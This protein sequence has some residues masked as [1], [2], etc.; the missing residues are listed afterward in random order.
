MDPDGQN[1]RRLTSGSGNEGEPA[2]TPDGKRLIY[3]AGSG[4]NTQIASVSVDGSDNRQLT[5]ASGGNHSPVVSAD[6]KSIVFVSAREGNHAIFRMNADGSGQR[7]ITKGSARETSPRF[8]PNGDLFYVVERGGKS[9]GSKVLRRGAGGG[10]SDLLQTDD[11][12]A[13]IAVSREGDRLIYLVLRNR[14]AVKGRPEAAV[15]LQ[16]LTGKA[17]PTAIPLQPGEQVST[18]SF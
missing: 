14:E 11:P 15:Y 9:K 6:G 10:T 1:Q 3:T 13:S 12:V 4:T 7:R 18:P 16:T 5:T 2:W 8:G 17:T